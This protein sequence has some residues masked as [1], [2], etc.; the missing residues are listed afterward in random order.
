MR[1]GDSAHF[2]RHFWTD[3]EKIKY[4]SALRQVLGYQSFNA[5]IA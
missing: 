4:N 2:H 5:N 1:F 3:Y